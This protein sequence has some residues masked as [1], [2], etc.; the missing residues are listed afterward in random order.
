[1]NKPYAW[2]RLL[3]GMLVL[4]P[5]WFCCVEAAPMNVRVVNGDV[6]SVLFSAARMGHFNLVLDDE[7]QGTVTLNM[8][9]EPERVMSLVAEAKGLLLFRDGQDYI[10]TVAGRSG[11]LSQLHSYKAK[12]AN[13]HDLVKAVNLSLANEGKYDSVLNNNYNDTKNEAGAKKTAG[14]NG[15]RALVDE[16]SGSVIFYGTASEAQAIEAVLR[17]LDVP[18]EQVSL[19]AKV[20]AL[21]RSA[22]KDLGV[23]WQ[24]S[25]LPQYPEHHKTRYKDGRDGYYTDTEIR[26]RFNG[27]EQIPGIIRFGHG[28]EGVPFEFY[29]G[30]K[31]N[32]MIAD[33]KAKMLARPNVTTLQGHE[34]VI[35]IG[36]EVPVPT[37]S[38]TD[39]STTTT[40]TYRQTGIILRCTPRVNTGGK[41]T[42]EV[43]TEVSSPLYVN[44]IKAYRFQKRSA[45]TT[46][47]LSD[48]ETMVIGGLI[49]SDESRTLSKVPFMGDIPILGS[50]FRD[51]KRN[52]SESEIM[53][54]L[55]AHI[56]KDFSRTKDTGQ[57]E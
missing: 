6:R 51:Y 5:W 26:R 16:T 15:D 14:C 9:E 8:T 31:I 53:I 50:F 18:A 30:A 52:R 43:H 10:V 33:G 42:A 44:D 45:D 28:P 41:I 19:E 37:Q 32:A 12:Y 2:N 1:M 13:P 3:V 55:T 17:L 39:S 23:E 21:S 4:F 27:S 56:L 54:F 29:F 7:V 20:I 49:G 22:S 34:A 38:V 25:T 24:W 48:G 40:L 36:G 47:R 35:N 11:S 46:V 57:C